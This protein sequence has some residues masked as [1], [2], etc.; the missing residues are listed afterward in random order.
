VEVQNTTSPP[1]ATTLFL[2]PDAA[3]LALDTFM[4]NSYLSSASWECAI[5]GGVATLVVI[6]IVYIL[7]REYT[8]LDK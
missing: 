1:A 6:A 3:Q 7:Y 5:M 8:N 2:L 4:D